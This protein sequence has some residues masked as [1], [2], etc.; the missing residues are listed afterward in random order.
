[1]DD[2][3]R[4]ENGARHAI[5]V[6]D[7]VILLRHEFA[8]RTLRVRIDAE[9]SEI[10]FSAEVRLISKWKPRKTGSSRRNGSAWKARS[11]TSYKVGCVRQ[12][13][14]QSLFTIHGAERPARQIAFLPSLGRRD[15]GT[16]NH[17]LRKC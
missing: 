15:T 16:A 11:I 17:R 10:P 4:R 7:R 1:V 8:D 6:F 12:L 3:E 9:I 14:A 13:I 5:Q 2:L